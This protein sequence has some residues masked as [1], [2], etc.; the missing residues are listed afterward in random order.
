MTTLRQFQINYCFQ[1]IKTMTSQIDALVVGQ[2]AMNARLDAL[3]AKFCPSITRQTPP[4]PPPTQ[5][6]SL[7]KKKRNQKTRNQY[8]KRAQ[9][10]AQRVMIQVQEV[11]HSYGQE[12]EHSIRISV[13]KASKHE[14]YVK[15]AVKSVTWNKMATVATSSHWHAVISYVGMTS[16][17]MIMIGL[18]VIGMSR[19]GVG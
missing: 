2:N 14:A 18:G 15:S 6:N 1:A 4:T 16:F 11:E 12:A 19:M 13:E 9:A 8:K 3:E 10:Q 17:G 7:A 5:P